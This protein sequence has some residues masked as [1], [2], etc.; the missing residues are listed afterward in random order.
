MDIKRVIHLAKIPVKVIA[1][2][3]GTQTAHVY[4]ILNGVRRPRLE[5]ADRLS[6]ATDGLVSPE[7]WM[8]I[9]PKKKGA[10]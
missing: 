6:H 2:R 10:K 8:R 4:N 5:L 1:G 3:A 7:E 9:P